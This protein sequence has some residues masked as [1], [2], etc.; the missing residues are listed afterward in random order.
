VFA[1]APPHADAEHWIV[2]RY[3]A[4]RGLKSAAAAG[5]LGWWL[6]REQRR[7]SRAPC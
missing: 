6:E 7:L 3:L 2:D 1:A 5:A 4:A